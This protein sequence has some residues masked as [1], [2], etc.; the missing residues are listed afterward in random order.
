MVD[1]AP[2]ARSTVMIPGSTSSVSTTARVSR[3]SGSGLWMD[4]KA[5]IEPETIPSRG[6]SRVNGRASC[7]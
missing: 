1:N 5:Q 7:T 6:G 4:P 3:R 2:M